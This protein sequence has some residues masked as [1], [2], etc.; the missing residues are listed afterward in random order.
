MYSKTGK[1]TSSPISFPSKINSRSSV[2]PWI[3]SK[4]LEIEHRM[5]AGS[6]LGIVEVSA[7]QGQIFW[8]S[9]GGAHPLKFSSTPLRKIQK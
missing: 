2:K 3:P 7:N 6:W 4:S 1:M 5:N 9:A 8:G